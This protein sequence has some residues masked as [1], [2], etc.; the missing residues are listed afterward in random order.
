MR[1]RKDLVL[2][3]LLVLAFGANLQSSSEGNGHQKIEFLVCW[4]LS[5]F[6][7]RKTVGHI[8]ALYT[9]LPHTS[10]YLL[11]SSLLPLSTTS[12]LLDLSLIDINNIGVDFQRV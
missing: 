5:F 6:V 9:T 1:Y 10:F 11:P 2:L 12:G 3:L 8:P 4:V 7:N